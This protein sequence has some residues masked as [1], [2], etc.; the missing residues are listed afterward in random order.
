MAVVEK[1]V[2]ILGDETLS[3][4]I[5]ARRIPEGN[6]VDFYDE[7]VKTLKNFALRGMAGMHT[8]N[9]PYVTTVGS[10]AFTNCPDLT[11]V[12]LPRAAKNFLKWNFRW[13]AVLVTARSRDASCWK[14]WNCPIFLIWRQVPLADVMR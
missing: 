12:I 13:F 6:P 1:T 9:F 5:L 7:A 8:V 4:F 14:V 10:Y 2:D 3:A 11:K